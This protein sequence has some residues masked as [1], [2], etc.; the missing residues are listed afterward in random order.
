MRRAVASKRIWTPVG[1]SRAVREGRTIEVSGTTSADEFGEV[2]HPQD[3]YG[4]TQECLR[5]IERALGELGAQLSDVV[6]TRVFLR[7]ISMWEEVGRAHAE[8]FASGIPPA[9]SFIGGADLLHPDLLVE[10]EATA[11]V[12][13]DS[14]DDVG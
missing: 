9:S 11:I 14:S 6:R 5:I 10:V 12:I 8:A 13:G 3:P 1:Y 4:Q 7:D 2:L